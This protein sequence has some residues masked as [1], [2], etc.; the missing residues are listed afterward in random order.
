MRWEG[1]VGSFSEDVRSPDLSKPCPIIH[2]MQL[3]LL[4]RIFL[5]DPS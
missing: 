4:D 1:R 3:I 5:N 2:L